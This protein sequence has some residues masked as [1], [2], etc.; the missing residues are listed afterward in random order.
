MQLVVI[1]LN[2]T[3]LLEDLLKEFA[4]YDYYGATILNSTGMARM[5]VR[6]GC[7]EEVFLKPL[8]L[9]LEPNTEDSKTILMITKEENIH[10]LEQIVNQVVGNIDEPDTAVFF[11][12]TINYLRGLNL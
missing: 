11:A 9:M 5:L 4:N 6:L 1:I 2:K 7:D 8:K 12:V 3:E 10:Q